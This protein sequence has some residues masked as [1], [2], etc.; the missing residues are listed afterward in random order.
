MHIMHWHGNGD[1]INKIYQVIWNTKTNWIVGL[2]ID[3]EN[4]PLLH[5]IFRVLDGDHRT[6]Q[7]SYFLQFMWR[8][9]TSNFD[10]IGPYLTQRTILTLKPQYL[11]FLRPCSFLKS[12]VS[13]FSPWFVM[14]PAVTCLSTKAIV[15]SHWTIRFGDQMC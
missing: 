15:W 11:A 3:I 9:I 4:L 8:D 10:A 2:A 6:H 1:N 14:E 13:K 12:M 7:A 5:E